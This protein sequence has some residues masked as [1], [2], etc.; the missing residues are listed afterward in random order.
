MS[1]KN[2]ILLI[3]SYPPPYG[4]CSVHI[5]RLRECLRDEFDISVLDLYS[6]SRPEDGRD[7]IYR[8]GT[9]RPINLL[10]AILKLGKIRANL[11][12]FHVAAMGNF[13]FAG[14]LFLAFIGKNTKKVISIHSGSFTIN[15]ANMGTVKKRLLSRLMRK[16]DHIISVN[17]EQRDLLESLGVQPERLMVAPAFLPPVAAAGERVQDVV[18]NLKKKKQRILISSGYALPIYGFKLIVDMLSANADLRDAFAVIF[19]FYNTYDAGYLAAVQAALEDDIDFAIFRDLDP[20][21]FAF[22]LSQ[23]DLYIRA[24]DRDGDAVA[25][26]EAAF[27]GKKIIASDVVKRPGGVVLFDISSAASLADAVRTS[28]RDTAAGLVHFDYHENLNKI[29]FIYRTLITGGASV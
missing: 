5:Q 27:F 6:A 24:T 18:A 29:S 10:K 17:A 22:V 19:C 15:T 16:F 26:R 9:S 8:C 12:H 21:E 13:L 3:G 28:M 23:S 2:K 7:H 20:S 25:I 11:I 1:N 4:G 14:F